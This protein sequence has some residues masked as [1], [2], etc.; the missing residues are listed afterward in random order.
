MQKDRR[1]LNAVRSFMSRFICII[2]GFCKVSLTL[3]KGT[4]HTVTTGAGNKE[5]NGPEHH[6]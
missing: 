6:L 4:V 2:K 1:Q 5:H 3:R